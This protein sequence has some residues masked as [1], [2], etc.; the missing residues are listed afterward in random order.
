VPN[1]SPINTAAAA[2]TASVLQEID[3][4]EQREHQDAARQ[5]LEPAVP[6]VPKNGPG[7]LPGRPP[8]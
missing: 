2:A 5:L 7:F 1:V 8:D 4:E 6:R 3:A